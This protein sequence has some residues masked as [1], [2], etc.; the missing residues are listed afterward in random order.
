MHLFICLFFRIFREKK[1]VN[2]CLWEG[3][4]SSPVFLY[5]QYAYKRNHLR[6]LFLFL[7]HSKIL[8]FTPEMKFT[9]FSRS[10]KSLHLL[11]LSKSKMKEPKSTAT[12]NGHLKT[13]SPIGNV[14]LYRKPSLTEILGL[15]STFEMKKP[16]EDAIPDPHRIHQ[17]PQV[18]LWVLYHLPQ[19]PHPL[20]S[21]VQI[22]SYKLLT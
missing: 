22:R 5:P 1:W 14:E 13:I 16:V 7:T 4:S 2:K 6:Y 11:Q 21:Y 10:R 18:V 8:L 9:Q 3:L 19:D 15:I 17:S 20:E 12:P